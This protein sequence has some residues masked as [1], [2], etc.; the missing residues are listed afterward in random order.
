M[1]K[2][3]EALLQAKSQGA[4]VKVTHVSQ[5]FRWHV[6]LGFGPSDG[7]MF[8]TLQEHRKRHGGDAVLRLELLFEQ[9]FPVKPPVLRVVGPVLRLNTFPIDHGFVVS[10]ELNA[11][12]AA[13]ATGVEG[14]VTSVLLSLRD[15][16][17]AAGAE[18]DVRNPCDYDRGLFHKVRA[19]LAKPWLSA[20]APPADFSRELCAWSGDYARGVLGLDIKLPPNF[21]S[22]N[23][24]LMPEMP[25]LLTG[26]AARVL[27]LIPVDSTA[28]RIPVSL[29]CGFF[30]PSAPGGTAILPMHMQQALHLPQGS[31]VLVRTIELPKISRITLRALH[32]DWMEACPVPIQ[33]FLRT[34]IQ[35]WACFSQGEIVRLRVTKDDFASRPDYKIH[36]SDQV[37]FS[38]HF[39]IAELA[40]DVP[41]AQ[42][43]T[44]FETDL[45]YSFL[46]ALDDP[47]SL[48]GASGAPSVWRPQQQAAGAVNWMGAGDALAGD[49]EPSPGCEPAAKEVRLGRVEGMQEGNPVTLRMVLSS[50]PT[51]LPA[52][53]G[54]GAD[55]GSADTTTLGAARVRVTV[56]VGD[57]TSCRDLYRLATLHAPHLHS[58]ERAASQSPPAE[59]A[60]SL[61]SPPLAVKMSSSASLLE[62]SS[63]DDDWEL[64]LPAPPGAMTRRSTPLPDSSQT[65]ASL[66]HG[67][68]R[69]TLTQVWAGLES[70]EAEAG[71][72][73]CRK[74]AEEQMTAASRPADESDDTG[75]TSFDDALATVIVRVAGYLSGL[76]A[77][78]ERATRVAELPAATATCNDLYEWAS[79]HLDLPDSIPTEL[80]V[81]RTFSACPVSVVAVGRDGKRLSGESD[82]DRAAG[83]LLGGA[84]GPAAGTGVSD[85]DRSMLL[86]QSDELL[87]SEAIG[88]R[89]GRVMLVEQF[90]Q[91]LTTC[92]VAGSLELVALAE[93]T[94]GCEAC[95]YENEPV[96]EACGACG[97]PRVEEH[98]GSISAQ[99][100]L[101]QEQAMHVV[102]SQTTSSLSGFFGEPAGFGK[103]LGRLSSLTASPTKPE[104]SDIEFNTAL[105]GVVYTYAVGS[106]RVALSA[107]HDC[108]WLRH[109]VCTPQTTVADIRKLSRSMVLQYTRAPVV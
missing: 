70:G 83:A 35:R 87:C 104:T 15:M 71:G 47:T 59:G 58:N 105:D 63:A 56:V 100:C 43:W 8:Q 14:G 16:L 76:D 55:D 50:A 1:R 17:I 57:Q 32:Y 41:T 23:K 95:G 52:A 10:K 25:P 26:G 85:Y 48:D 66:L 12:F 21:E 84:T 64:V 79:S 60:G 92:A 38:A 69:A 29:P 54:S 6:E 51:H 99:A 108:L 75:A 53:S 62:A 77:S 4:T 97:T 13:C 65:I 19:R 68:T 9:G 107:R 89:P 24:I 20:T 96:D 11:G 31:R 94:W 46:P 72:A 90:V 103:R 3:L 98:R 61:R 102:A 49:S 2:T 80:R 27:E 73:D 88:C 86:P 37:E 81:V 22:G 39:V 74:P 18:V 33:P 109:M 42:I 40:P 34:A 67:R 82:S 101:G 44:G 30:G 5:L 45:K 78:G 28:D 36:Q 91:P 93:S 106:E 7:S